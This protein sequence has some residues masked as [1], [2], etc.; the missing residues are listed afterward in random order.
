MPPERVDHKRRIVAPGLGGL[1]L[2]G[3][4]A[5][6]AAGSP[7][8]DAAG[9]RVGIADV[10]MAG[11]SLRIAITT[12]GLHG[13]GRQGGPNPPAVAV[14]VWFDGAPVHVQLPLIHMPSR[15]AMD[16]D[17]AA[18]VIRVG[19]ASVARFAPVPPFRENAR[20]PVEV[21][22]RRGED[23]AVAHRTAAILL[24]TVI[25]PGYLN[26]DDGPSA[27]VLSAFRHRGYVDAGAGQNVFWFTYPSKR[28]AVPDGGRAL[29]DY[30]RRVVL[31]SGHAAAVNVV[32][33]SLGG[34]I[35]RWNVAYDV[36]GWSTL[37]NRLVLVGVPNEGTV[38]AYLAGHAP[39][40][41]PFAGLGHTPASRVFMPTFPFWRPGPGSPWALPP[42]A[43]NALLDGLNARPIP[44]DIRIYLFYGSHDP[45]H[46]AG[47]QTS[48][49]ITGAL[50][51][52]ALAYEAGD[53]LI[54]AASAQGL[55]IQG[56]EGVPALAERAVLRVD[57]GSVYHTQLL[58]AGAGR[59]AGALLDRFENR[60]GRAMDGSA[61]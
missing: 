47:P 33:Y 2:L 52:A 5:L 3:L 8:A 6:S 21:T 13:A 57:L 38:M 60:A 39:S 26:E 61:W 37:V 30:V 50:P 32:G 28:L 20:V 51:D 9:L 31:P 48:A 17:L 23:A 7:A 58:D 27:A 25:V 41:L 34:L 43:E 54:L 49:G 40:A 29:A 59:I 44:S 14:S 53:G 22:L 11:P 46:P 1:W 35:A 4:L 12:D 36:D 15:F 24:P 10:R 45:R 56:G 42:D 55:P 18:G 16:F 19:G